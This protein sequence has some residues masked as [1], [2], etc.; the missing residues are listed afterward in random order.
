MGDF[1]VDTVAC[2]LWNCFWVAVRFSTRESQPIT[3]DLLKQSQTA[4]GDEK[5]TSVLAQCIIQKGLHVFGHHRIKMPGR[6]S[7]CVEIGKF[8]FLLAVWRFADTR[9]RNSASLS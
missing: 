3:G 4:V 6:L 5:P 2:L 7:H 9:A 8:W 1:V